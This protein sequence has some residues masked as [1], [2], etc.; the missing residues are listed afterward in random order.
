MFLH[1]YETHLMEYVLG[2]VYLGC[3]VGFWKYVNF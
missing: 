1:G 3:F 2:V